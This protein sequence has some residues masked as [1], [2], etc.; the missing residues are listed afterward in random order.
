MHRENH[1]VVVALTT[2]P[3]RIQFLGPILQSLFVNQ[4]KKVDAVYLTLPRKH[5]DGTSTSYEIPKGVQNLVAKGNLTILSPE[6]D[7]GPISKVFYVLELESNAT[8]IL[9]LDDDVFYPPH[10]IEALYNKSIQYPDEVVAFSGSR[11]RSNFSKIGHTDPNKDRFPYLF[12]QISGHRTFYGEKPVDIV[13]GFLGVIVQPRFFDLAALSTL[14]GEDVPRGVRNSDDFVL[15]A[16]FEARNITRR[17]VS[18]LEYF[19]LHD[20]AAQTDRLSANMQN[21]AMEAASYL[22]RSLGI[23][24]D[25]SFAKCITLKM[26]SLCA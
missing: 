9:Y 1:R 26:T 2:I 14:V 7:H 8:R 22:Q 5:Y 21:N 4:T 11:L 24:Q 13:Q 10:F 12:F 18:G 3:T 19:R 25:Y 15:S 16:H 6:W 20:K 23:W 17:I